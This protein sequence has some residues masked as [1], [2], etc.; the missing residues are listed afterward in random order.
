[1]SVVV[2]FAVE[3]F[4][5]ESSSV[6]LL[7]KSLL[8]QTKLEAMRNQTDGE[9][10]P[11]LRNPN[12]VNNNT[13]NKKT[14]G[15]RVVIS[16]DKEDKPS[17][18][19]Q[20]RS[21]HGIVSNR[22]QNDVET[23]PPPPLHNFRSS[24]TNIHDVKR[25]RG[26]RSSYSSESQSG[27]SVHLLFLGLILTVMLVLVIGL[28]AISV[29]AVSI[30]KEMEP[31]DAYVNGTLPPTLAPTLGGTVDPPI[32]QGTLR[33]IYDRGFLRCGITLGRGRAYLNT[34]TNQMQGFSVDLVSISD[35][36]LPRAFYV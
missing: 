22:H 10:K 16:D 14:R 32:L 11:N 31:I 6:R 2:V 3:V 4:K 28:I 36:L 19:H 12:D 9:G 26:R 15:K 1:V 33:E 7:L 29:I 17:S 30:N 20:H 5:S 23:G 34:T 25:V 24:L 35:E 18:L 8:P 27:P 13:D 21:N